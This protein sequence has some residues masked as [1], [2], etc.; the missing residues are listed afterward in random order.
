MV[1][2]ICEGNDH[3]KRVLIGRPGI[4]IVVGAEQAREPQLLNLRRPAFPPR[5]RQ[6]ILPFN[7]QRN[8][9]HDEYYLSHELA[10]RL[11]RGYVF[12]DL[13]YR[14][15]NFEGWRQFCLLFPLPCPNATT[16]ARCSAVSGTLYPLAWLNRSIARSAVKPVSTSRLAA[17]SPDLP[18]PPRQ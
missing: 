15:N 1:R 5:P 4:G 9:N 2:K 13:L 14:V 11:Q 7:L 16:H 17:I 12:S 18:I 6:P 3:L 8:I 10:I